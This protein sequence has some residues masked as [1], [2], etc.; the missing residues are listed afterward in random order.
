M[1]E[2][3]WQRLDNVARAS[4]PFMSTLLFTFLSV[5]AWP[6][7]YIGTVMP[8][9]ALIAIYYWAIHRPDLFGPGMAFIIGLLFDVI[10]FLPPGLSALLFVG[11]H[12]FVF[13]QRRFFSGHSFLMLW[14][15]FALTVISFIIIE[16]IFLGII[17]WQI[18]PFFPVFMQAILV[19]FLFPLPCWMLI[20]LQRSALSSN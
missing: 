2:A 19:I 14:S 4:L 15:G 10:N 18:T 12:Q 7:P 13:W 11:V 5:V 16:W 20:R 1:L 3:L 8:P 9:L 6:L 17:R